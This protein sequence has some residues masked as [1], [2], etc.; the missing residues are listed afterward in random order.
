MSIEVKGEVKGS[1]VE[2]AVKLK[3]HDALETVRR[4]T[5]WAMGVGLIPMPG[6]D[7]IGVTG[8]QIKMLNELSRLYKV[9]FSEHRAKSILSALAGGL[10]ALA[11]APLFSSLIKVIPIVGQTAGLVSLPL[12][13]G[14]F[15]YA[16]GKIFVQHF[17]TGG[18]LLD[19][20]PAAVREHFRREFESA[21]KTV[22]DLKSNETKV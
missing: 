18:T 8:V 15:T 20:D 12:S 3:D 14:A 6:L 4:N 1:G 19:F 16:V 11:V 22:Q 2:A 7:L 9:D 10:G 21:K 5:L 17:S 13:A